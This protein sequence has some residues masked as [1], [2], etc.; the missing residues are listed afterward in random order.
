MKKIYAILFFCCTLVASAQTYHIGDLYTAPDGSQGIVYYI[1][2]DGSGGWVVALDDA[3][4]GCSWGD[5]NDVPGLA[6]QNPSTIQNLLNDTAGY[7]N[8]QILRNYQNNN[9]T[10]AAGKVDF[11]HGWV[12]PSL[13]QLSMLYGQLPFITSA[14][15]GAGGTALAYGV[16]W[17]SSEKDASQAW[18][19]DFGGVI[20]GASGEFVPYSGCFTNGF[21]T[22]TSR[23]VRAVRS[24]TYQTV[25]H[26]TSLTY[27]WNT[28]STQ[29]Y[30]NVSP[31][32]TTTYTVTGTTDYGCSATA[33]Q[34][35]IVGTGSSQTIYDTI[36]WGEGYEANGF[37]LTAAQT[38]T[39]GTITRSRTITASGCSSTL[40]LR[41]LIRPKNSTTFTHTACGSYTWNGVTYYD[42]GSYSQ[43][44]TNA[45]GCDSVV[46]MNLTI[47]NPTHT[48]TTITQC[49]SYIW[50]DV[51]YTSSGTYTYSHSDDN[52]CTQVDTL[53]LTINQLHTSEISVTACESYTWYESTYTESGAYTQTFTA[54]NGCDSV[55]TLHL[56]LTDPPEV[57][58]VAI[59]DTICEGNEVVLQAIV[60]GGIPVNYVPPVAIG[61]ILCTDGSIVKTANW[62]VADKTAMGIVFYVDNTG[63]H[64]WAMNLY[65]ENSNTT[66]MWGGS[67]TDIPALNNITLARSALMDLDGYSNTQRIRAA[68]T[69]TTYPA[70]WSV[71]FDNGW[72]MPAAGQLRCIYSQLP[73]LN[74]SLQTVGGLQFSMSAI[75]GY[76]SSTESDANQAWHLDE[77]GQITSYTKTMTYKVR[78]VR[79]F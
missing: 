76:W 71:A 15:V 27:Q 67:G 17:C 57:T 74:A 52:G 30:I 7:I 5:A 54:A 55:V 65:N 24:F 37:S 60:P 11:A 63:I 33:E 69:A 59:D 41:L 29:P 28:G 20:D 79:N 40:T 34:T 19:V 58:I 62:P 32:Q 39:M 46:T 8:T 66:M 50:H 21:K 47:Y 51:T 26:D 56:T 38:N 12:L 36:C 72:Y 45:T 22:S 4:T 18:A 13:A 64:G 16:Y 42:S 23:R 6:N 49:D 48:A 2:P 35:I 78:A 14:I 77:N 75:W 44:F 1:H 10:Y 73:T 9:T 68:G 61:D 53:H 3:S 25:V 43:T 31:S 70:A